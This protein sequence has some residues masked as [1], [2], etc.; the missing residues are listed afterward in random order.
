M[1]NPYLAYAYSG[2]VMCTGVSD[3][4]A[5][6]LFGAG[7]DARPVA[8]LL[9]SDDPGHHFFRVPYR[10]IPHNAYTS[11]D[12][13]ERVRT[14]RAQPP[15]DYVVDPRREGAAGGRPADPPAVP[16]HSV[17]YSY[18]AASRQYLRS[19]H[20]RPFTDQVSGAQVHARTVVLLH[21][22]FHDGGWVEDD[23]GGA[24]S[25]WYDLL[26]SGPA[27]VYADGT[28]VHATWHMG[29]APGQPYYENHTPVWF[30]D[31]SGRV[32]QLGAGLT[33]IHVLGNGQERCPE[34]P[35]AC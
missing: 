27:E 17:G 28:V 29:A 9:E 30:G 32:L 26:G 34:S 15:G 5:R 8:G 22:P 16:L 7:P 20:G 23:T 35:S 14:E 10:A 3:G 4:T 2:V 6:Y 11:G 24:H 31:E 18:D 21:V 12:R 13:A 1:V 33:W 25:V 19:D